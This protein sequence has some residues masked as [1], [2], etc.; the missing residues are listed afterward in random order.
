MAEYADMLLSLKLYQEL[1]RSSGRDAIPSTD[2]VQL[3]GI[4]ASVADFI[5][6]ALQRIPLTFRQ[7][8]E[9]DFRHCRNLVE[10]MGDF[11]PPHTLAKLNALELSL[12]ILAA[13]L[14]DSG[15]IVGDEEKLKTLES[16]EFLAFRDQTHA[17]SADEIAEAKLLGK[18]ALARLMEDSVLAEYFRRLHPE[19]VATYLQDNLIDSLLFRDIDLADHLAQLCESHGWGVEDSLDPYRPEKAIKHIDDN[20]RFYRYRV[21]LQYLACCLRLADIMDFDRSRTPLAVFRQIEF[22]ESK[23]WDEWN[24]HLQVQGL[25]ISATR[26]S[27]DIPCTHP[28]FYVSIHQFLDKIDHEIRQCRYLTENKPKDTAERY[29]FSLPQAVDRHKVRMK[30][31]TYIAGAFRF[32]LEFSEI[33]RLL[34]D[35]SLYPSNSLFL[36]ELLQNSLDACR[37]KAAEKCLAE[38]RGSYRGK[39]EV[40]DKS[41]EAGNPHIIVE[42]NGIG[43]SLRIVEQYFMRVGRSYYRSP[44]FDLERAKLQAAGVELEACSQFGIGILSCFLVADRFEVDTFQ[45]GHERLHIVIEGPAKYFLIRRMPGIHGGAHGGTGTKITVHLREPL[46]LQAIR[47]IEQFAVNV[48]FEIT[49]NGGQK[50]I[51]RRWEQSIKVPR[52][53]E[54]PSGNELSDSRQTISLENVL[55][56]W[57][58][59]FEEWDFS[60]HLRGCAW[61]W[62]LRSKSEGVCASQGFLKISRSLQVVGAAHFLMQLGRVFQ[63]VASDESRASFLLAKIHEARGGSGIR[64]AVEALLEEEFYGV[65]GN[66]NRLDSWELEHLF[67][68]FDEFWRCVDRLNVDWQDLTLEEH[69][70]ITAA[71]KVRYLNRQDRPWEVQRHR[72]WMAIEG[73]FDELLGGTLAW[74]NKLSFAELP[75]GVASCGLPEKVEDVALFGIRIPE[76]IVEWRDS[77]EA[78]KV[79]LF[80]FPGGCQVDFRGIRAPRPAAHRLFIPY[81]RSSNT[82]LPIARAVLRSCALLIG[83]QP[84]NLAWRQW[85]ND[86]WI[87]SYP[88]AVMATLCRLDGQ[89]LEEKCRCAVILNGKLHALSREQL[90]SRFG[91]NI[92]VANVGQEGACQN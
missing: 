44:E 60:S 11:I 10:H 62:L 12:L 39:I 27:F 56:P 46:D 34:M 69:D 77:I 55:V 47:V 49:V 59:P 38:G 40:W 36:R 82:V 16:P 63:V 4:V 67:G 1:G 85:F 37:R 26:I 86:L 54:R 89:Y 73:I 80:P 79:K 92:P 78:T 90:V 65:A 87:D 32:Q 71:L 41:T 51:A 18:A 20:V 25:E 30:D 45:Q 88:A 17:D 70:D 66:L 50:I 7:Y 21:N 74:A 57:I 22:T 43:M 31:P 5:G 23:S 29:Q 76:G 81:E 8:T 33:V 6:P 28:A 2:V 9:H 42:D 52:I 64:I 84:N 24:K 68:D 75:H 13:L 3:Q 53:Q 14:H 35:K 15:M 61:L 91:P 72:Q 48:D 19:R 83:R 58:I